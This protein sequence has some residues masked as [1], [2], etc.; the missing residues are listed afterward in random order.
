[1]Q[2]ENPIIL[3]LLLLLIVPIIIHLFNLR[4]YQN[5][6]FSNLL[7]LKTIKKET[8]KKRELKKWMILFCRLLLIST[9]IL[10]F[11]RPYLKSENISKKADLFSIYI[12]NSL[13]MDILNPQTNKNLIEEAKDIALDIVNDL[14]EEQ[15]INIITNNYS[16]NNQNFQSK[17]KA[18]KIINEIT[19]SPF[20]T[21]I[22]DILERQKNLTNEKKSIYKF[23]ISDF[24][25][26]F[27]N[28]SKCDIS[29]EDKLETIHLTST[30]ENNISINNCV[31]EQPFHK[32]G[33]KSTMIIEFENHG[34]EDLD[35]IQFR[36]Y[37]NDTKRGVFSMNISNGSIEKKYIDIINTDDG[38]M[39]GKIELL[40]EDSYIF[41]NTLFFSYEIKKK[42]KI[43]S[44]YEDNPTEEISAV[45]NDPLF[46]FMQYN[47]N[48]IRISELK[49]YDLIIL[50]HLVMIPSGFDFNLN[51]ILEK[52]HN[53]LIL[54][55]KRLD[56]ESYNSFL[57]SYSID[58]LLEWK[59]K[60]I[61]TNFINTNHWVFSNVFEE[62]EENIDLPIINGYF[63]TENQNL[64]KSRN[65]ILKL[66]NND[67][68]LAEYTRNGGSI[69]LC[70][71]PLNS[72][73]NNFTNHA[74]FL[75]I[76]HNIC[77]NN[78]TQTLYHTIEKNLEIKLSNIF[79]EIDIPIIKYFEEQ[80]EKMSFFPD[81]KTTK[82]NNYL[83]L[84][85]D[86][87]TS[88]NYHIFSKNI[89]GTNFRKY[90]SLNYQRN[91]GHFKSDVNHKKNLATLNLDLNNF[92]KQNIIE[93]KPIDLHFYLIIISIFLFLTE[94][95]L[96][97]FWKQ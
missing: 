71:S 85:N 80:K 42:I 17:E 69:F 90:L 60:E 39:F 81:L 59:S 33:E 36:L 8:R 47:K 21:N 34:K 4:K 6:F 23:I 18:I 96:L 74:I 83:K 89:S 79:S 61:K 40:N 28:N 63:K 38:H 72:N 54:P 30:Y 95:L 32:K 75:P 64:T 9:L 10:T 37:I 84:N 86:I 92:D 97:K 31:F 65:N 76:M 14:D 46:E 57:D 7:V 94:L 52:E 25:K 16:Y 78:N 13:S 20:N 19:T 67:F 58:N 82:N 26:K 1:M 2:F 43:L 41:D 73:Y 91:E 50:D 3:Y 68:F 35:S 49:K 27:I 45:F 5:V 70:T 88:G 48:Q 77:R 66:L 29:E 93:K 55:S 53:L 87:I 51:Q 11:A 22:C 62:I 12:D 15:K 44:I 56:L 24:D